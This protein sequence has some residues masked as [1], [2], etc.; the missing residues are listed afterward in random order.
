MP[1]S[2]PIRP[3]RLRASREEGVF[4]VSALTGDGL[5]GFLEAV[6]RSLGAERRLQELVLSYSDGRKRAW[7]FGKGLVEA[8]TQD[9]D[10]F[11]LTVTWSALDRARFDAMD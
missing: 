7:L 4:L 8:E 3:A 10:G 1:N 6:T 5:S 11:H 2:S 9:E